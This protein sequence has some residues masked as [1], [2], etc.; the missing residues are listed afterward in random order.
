M[1]GVNP[2]YHPGIF[3]NANT[4]KAYG[5]V[6]TQHGWTANQSAR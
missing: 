6:D 1:D 2:A 3:R 4:A 5:F